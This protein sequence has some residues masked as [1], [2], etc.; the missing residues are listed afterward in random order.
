MSRG[1]T[2]S[3]RPQPL[4]R[5]VA[6][7][8]VRTQGRSKAFLISGT[9]LALALVALV[10]TN[11][12]LADRTQTS[13]VA[14]ADDTAAAA[15]ERGAAAA[16]AAD[17]NLVV[18]ASRQEDAASAEAAVRAGEADL[19]LLPADGGYELVGA[20][21]VDGA[22]SELVSAALVQTVT[23]RNAA[24]EGVDLAALGRGADVEERL[25]DPGPEDEALRQV[26]AFVFV[27][28]FYVTALSFGMTMASSVTQ[29]KESRVVE[30]LAAAVP[31]RSLLWG[32]VAGTSVLAVGQTLV[33]VAVGAGALVATGQTEALG[34]VGPAM[35]W[36]VAFFVLGFV[37]LAAV[38][39]VAGALASR[40]QDLQASTSP[41]Q[42]LLF[43]PYI[44]AVTAGEQVQTVVSML[45][46]T[47]TMLMP[48]RLAQGDVPAWQLAV[49]VLTTVLAAGLLVRLSV[50]VWE[51]TV[52]QTGA[53]IGFREAWRRAR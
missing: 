1:R 35:G 22:A 17:R 42:I 19:A 21:D 50:R 40:Q 15:V 37:A 48:A 11:A 5:V 16:E 53:R 12:V 46:I 14:V 51:R 3:R 23:E 41:L 24:Q 52:L 47:A 30:I 25:L 43:A 45:P 31:V 2:D 34:V 49:A 7:R 27:A 28:L 44:I 18:E 39:S 20:E 26:A 9:V 10:V 38:W 13:R 4:W 6:G 32:K 36:Y 33:L 29:E 8:E